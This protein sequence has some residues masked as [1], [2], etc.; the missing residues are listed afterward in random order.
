MVG[1][2][3]NYVYCVWWDLCGDFGLFCLDSEEWYFFRVLFG[4]SLV[5]VVGNFIC[6]MDYGFYGDFGFIGLNWYL[7]FFVMVF[8]FNCLV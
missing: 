1:N 7:F 3:V 4:V 8:M 2:F 5:V 6:G